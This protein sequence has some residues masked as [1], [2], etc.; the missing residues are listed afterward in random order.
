MGAADCSS[1]PSQAQVLRL[2]RKPVQQ[3]EAYRARKEHG[4]NME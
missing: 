4:Q 3:I 2:L 1:A